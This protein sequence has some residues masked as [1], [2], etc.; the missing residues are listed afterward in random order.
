MLYCCSQTSLF[1]SYCSLIHVD[2]SRERMTKEN[3]G[4]NAINKQKVKMD[5]IPSKGLSAFRN[6]TISLGVVAGILIVVVCTLL[7][8][9]VKKPP[10]CDWISSE[11]GPCELNGQQKRFVSCPPGCLCPPPVP[12]ISRACPPRQCNW[13]V[14]DWAECENGTQERTVECERGCVCAPPIPSRSQECEE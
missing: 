5:K 4:P 11:W 8:K 12:P 13:Q 10:C 6:A 2:G 7:F 1:V 14:S 3:C 9:V